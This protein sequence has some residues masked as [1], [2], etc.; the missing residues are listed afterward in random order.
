MKEVTSHIVN[1]SPMA[2]LRIFADT[3]SVGPGGAPNHYQVTGFDLGLNACF[4]DQSTE[5]EL[6]KTDIFFQHGNP[7]PMPNG[8]TIEV[9]LAIAAD[10]LEG[11]QKGPYA[12]P[13][14]ATALDHIYGALDALKSREL[15][16]LKPN[17]V[18]VEVTSNGV[19]PAGDE[20]REIVYL[21]QS[22]RGYFS[23]KT[24]ETIHR[25]NGIVSS[26]ACF[27]ILGDINKSDLP[28][29]IKLEVREAIEK[30]RGRTIL[31]IANTFAE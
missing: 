18:L 20:L 10:R 24:I 26:E 25:G 30:V 1:D 2:V 9:L 15:S 31:N 17:D 27:A 19:A 28:E 16:Y 4:K 22:V 5:A 13:K 7:S 11:F 29:R 8:L 3:D 21:F 6:F 14:N 12:H 23:Q